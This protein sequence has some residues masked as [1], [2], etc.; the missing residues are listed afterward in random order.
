MIYRSRGAVR[1]ESII[2][3]K[4]PQG[5]GWTRLATPAA[6]DNGGYPAACWRHESGIIGISAV[7]VSGDQGEASGPVY[8]LSI[9]APGPSRARRQEANWTLR[10]FGL[11]GA[12]E[13]NHVPG[14]VVRNFWRPVAENRIGMECPC[15]AAEPVMR[16]DKG[17]FEWRGVS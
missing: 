3:P 4:H 6:F 8:H 13:D 16:E 5:R 9:S 10:Q 17:D 2:K 7:E 14:G 11:D 1:V 15:K 12:E